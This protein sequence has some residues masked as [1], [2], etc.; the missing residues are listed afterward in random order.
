M[1]AYGPGAVIGPA[2]WAYY[3]LIVTTEGSADF[4][5][6]EKAF[7]S[8]A[9]DAFLIPPGHGF[10]GITGRE[11]CTIWVQ[12]FSQGKSKG[13]LTLPS[14]PTLWTSAANAEWPRTLMKQISRF[15]KTS[16]ATVSL[17]L[18]LLIQEFQYAQTMEPTLADSAALVIRSTT[19]WLEKQSFPLPSLK[20]I[21]THTGWSLSHFRDQFR[22]IDGRPVGEFIKDLR[23]N[24]AARLLTE[25]AL[26]IKAIAAHLGYSDI[27][28]FHRAFV[29]TKMTTPANYRRRIPRVF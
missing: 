26:P 7:S 1:G 11:G 17:L 12:H 19:A 8:V 6:G 2:K 27:V 29:R 22:L 25:T 5:V 20:E 10:H 3:D 15:H 24:E 4:A 23:M 28:A 9:G 13:A 21:A 18:R 14:H 16:S